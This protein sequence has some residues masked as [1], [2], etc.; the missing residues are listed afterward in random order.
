M[1]HLNHQRLHRLLKSTSRNLALLV[2]QKPLLPMLLSTV[3]KLILP[4]LNFLQL[5]ERFDY[6]LIFKRSNSV[7]ASAKLLLRI[8]FLMKILDIHIQVLSLV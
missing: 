5:A 7:G 1:D 3:C 8:A 6:L 2:G 4:S